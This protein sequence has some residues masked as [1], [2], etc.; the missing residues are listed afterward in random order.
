MAGNIR[1]YRKPHHINLGMLIF[2]CIAIYVSYCVYFYFTSK[3]IVGYE[4]KSGTLSVNNVYQGIALRD[5]EI[6]TSAKSGYVNYYARESGRVAVGD[7]VY[8]VDETGKLSEMVSG[9]DP[10][11]NTLSDS[12][13]S[14][15]KNEILDFAHNFDTTEYNKVYDFKY[16]VQGTV[17][18]LANYQ[19][20]SD[21]DKINGGNSGAIVNFITAQKSG[22]IVYSID[23]YEGVSAD[24]I[25]MA[26][27]DQD[28][29]EKKPLISNELINNGDPVYK[30]CLSEDWSIVIPVSEERASELKEAEYVKV[31]FLKNQTESWGKV[32]I[33]QNEDDYFAELGFNNSMLSFCTDR[34]IDIELISDDEEGLKIPNSS[35]IQKEFFLVPKEYIVRGGENGNDGVLLETYTEDGSAT[36]EFI[37]TPIYNEDDEYYYLDDTNLSIGDYIIKPNS[38]DK[39]A[40]SKHSELIGVYNINKGYADFKQ[41]QILYQNDEYSI[42]KSNTMYG[43]SVYDYIVLDASSVSID[44]FV[45]E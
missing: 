1:K 23:G 13:L 30:I 7:L 39:Y 21:M 38:L 20:I 40:I 19:I 25:N 36:T 42:V 6:V 11:E 14:E 31:K 16:S 29:Y 17:T 8:S 12:D 27:F 33:H 4:V 43:L 15:L 32:T 10:D 45:F 28:S 24:H 34:F 37:S 35:I 44:D 5:E 22:V 9:G 18:K 3:H 41:I 2:V 26:S